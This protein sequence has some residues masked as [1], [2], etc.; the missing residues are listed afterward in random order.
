VPVLE[1]VIPNAPEPIFIN[2]QYFA[3]ASSEQNTIAEPIG[4]EIVLWQSV[5]SAVALHILADFIDFRQRA[6]RVQ[7]ERHSES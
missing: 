7:A 5:G 3:A 4:L 6:R 2:T 1:P